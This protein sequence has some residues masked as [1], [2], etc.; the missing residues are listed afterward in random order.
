MEEWRSGGV[1]MWRSEGEWRGVLRK[2]RKLDGSEE[3]KCGIIREIFIQKWR[4]R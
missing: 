4:W 3:R 2:K 1:E